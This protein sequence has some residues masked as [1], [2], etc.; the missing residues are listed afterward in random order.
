MRGSARLYVRVLM[1][2]ACAAALLLYQRRVA[3]DTV[4]QLLTLEQR[5]NDASQITIDDNWN[6]VPGIVGYRGDGLAA[7]T[8]VDPQTILVDGSLVVDV[9]AN[10]SD[11]NV[12]ATG[13]VTEFDGIGDPSVALQGSGTA[14]AP[15]L[16]IR[17]N[18][19]GLKSIRVTYNVRDIDGSADN[20]VQRVALQYRIGNS[21]N[22]TNL[23]AGFVAD[24]TTG[25]SATQ[26]TPVDVILPDDAE[27]KPEV[28]VR[29]ITSDAAGSDEW[30]GID[31]IVITGSA[32]PVPTNPTGAGA[33]SPGVITASLATK[34]T[35]SVTPGTNPTST[36]LA[37]TADLSQL[38]GASS[39]PLFDDGTHGDV[40][41]GDNVFTLDATV[42]ISTPDGPLVLPATVSDAQLRST[43]APIAL[44]VKG[45]HPLP[46][47]QDW[48]D[49]T[50]ISASNDWRG[51]P[52]VIGY[53]GDAL[54]N[55]P[56]T[57]PQTVTADG[58]A[59]P[60]NVQANLVNATST[61]GG[62]GEFHLADPTVAMQGSGTAD[63]PH[64]VV[65]LNTIGAVS[66]KVSYD[67][68]D[69]DDTT[70]NAAQPVAVQYRI[71]ATGPFTNVPTGFVPDATDGPSVAGRTTHVSVALPADAVNQ[72]LVQVRFITSD[73]SGTDEWVGIDNIDIRSLGP[74]PTG[75][76]LATPDSAAVGEATLLT[77]AVTPG[78]EPVSTGIQ[79]T[80]D[81]SLIGGSAAQPLVDDGTNGDATAGD[82]VFSYLATIADGTTAA[83]IQL[84]AAISDAQSRTG[85]AI[86]VLTVLGPTAPAAVGMA[87]PNPVTVGSAVLLTANVTPGDNPP[88]TALAVRVD[89]TPLGGASATAFFDD[90]THG[91]AAGG[92]QI[93]SL[94][95]S[96]PPATPPGPKTL[97]GVV[98]D[99]ELRSSAF[100]IAVTVDPAV[101][102]IH[103][104][105]GAGA[106][107]P[108]NGQQVRT[109][110]I[111]TAKRS[112][113]FYM[114]APQGEWDSQADT[115]E[116]VFVFTQASPPAAAAVGSLVEVRATVTEF[117]PSADVFQLPLTELSFPVVT[118]LANAQPVPAPIPLTEQDVHAGSSVDALERYEGMRVSVASLTA[119]APNIAN[120]VNENN[121][122]GSSSATFYGVITGTARPFREPGIDAFDP[123]P[124]GAP[125]TIPRFDTNPERF[126]I[127]TNGLVGVST[128]FV[129]TGQVVTNVVGVM[130]Y[131][132]RTYTIFPEATLVPAGSIAIR[133]V[134]TPTAN[135]F[136]VASANLQRFFDTVNDPD[137]GEPVLTTTAF[138]N[139]LNKV[140]LMI[141]D[142]LRTPDIVGVVEVENLNALQQVA[143]KVNADAVTAGAP[144]PN[145]VAYLEEGN[146]PGGIDSG[147]LVKSSRVSVIDVTQYS[148]NTTYSNPNNGQFELLNDRPPLVLRAVVTGSTGGAFP[149]TVIANHM[150]SLSSVDDPADGNR[151]RTKRRAQAEDLAKLVQARQ[152]ANPNERILLVGDFNA[153]PFN[154]GYVDSIGTIKG[155]PTAASQ[156][157]L[158]SPDLVNPDLTN[159]LDTVN[160]AE[161]Y[162]YTFDGNAQTLDQAL[163]TSNLLPLVDSLQ[164][165]RVNADFLE[166]FRND[167][168]SPARIS[169]HD[170]L[171][172]FVDFPPP[173]VSIS[174]VTVT[175]G[176]A[177][178]TSAT[179]TVSL[180][181]ASPLP[182][183]VTFR[184]VDGT[185]VAG[186]DY[187]AIA[188]TT[189]TFAPGTTTQ[190]ITVTVNGD[191]L[192]ELNESF[193]VELT[194][195]INAAIVD[196]QGVGTILNDDAVTISIDDVTVYEPA[197]GTAQAVLT[198]TLSAPFTE[199]VTVR[200]GTSNGSA[201]DGADFVGIPMNAHTTLTFA[202]GETAKTVSITV[203]SDT[204]NERSEFFSVHLTNAI[205]AE[206][207][208]SL[209][210]VTVLP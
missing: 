116:G 10:R 53:R 141:R 183:S 114:Q 51:V 47:F 73:A 178:T 60:V 110:G 129:S 122:T 117:V 101:I 17:L 138:N 12:F 14:R 150:R 167:A 144:N 207:L 35:V 189:L 142:V 168:N 4:P 155:T 20:A 161:R 105:Q 154:D 78:S 3:A 81:I 203:N 206:V 9:N 119:I 1:L 139:R 193:R 136:T 45:P 84:P 123:L 23:P 74:D 2:L 49:I 156:V 118:L 67:L 69:I 103:D 159:L 11:P 28:N 50:Q 46:F 185:A 153:F 131:G 88:S 66:V 82:N 175:E 85:A 166:S 190:T 184:T 90:G 91:D 160:P 191:V 177:G 202:P 92:D 137:I 124:P 32:V 63:A 169:D 102:A 43:A 165:A 187:A 125:S 200:H 128:A 37:V 196:A 99:G 208:K 176:N 68:R 72:P 181:I 164:F 173:N 108:F 112:N 106:M 149:I 96:V 104:V 36:G 97:A 194:D 209:G 57:D 120:S 135:Q 77:V 132:F 21:G 157:T 13:G 199:A 210:R 7:T 8:N 111:V 6:G 54:S 170:P 42:P 83:T 56:G 48:S 80:A 174:D 86:I 98:T 188:P 152:A 64:L 171:V 95:A 71:G 25:G 93:F 182:A 30:V 55:S 94:T 40:S 29:I 130:D 79:V 15:N 34:L 204:V 115:S 145:Y 76:G 146:D 151:V 26:V 162:S 24:A 52:S 143:A 39:E 89:L 87:T 198:V 5:W 147:F 27:N 65:M 41:A 179:F 100:D 134:A 75:S 126:R 158:A 197:S 133:P 148:K 121:A 70:D 186:S 22:Y 33:A 127:V 38:G 107:S 61:A 205:N 31:D 18:T 113:G 109:R 172:V 44:H 62:L 163:I 180:S 140:S 195:P 19:T 59:T 192:S 16:V 201:H 58:S